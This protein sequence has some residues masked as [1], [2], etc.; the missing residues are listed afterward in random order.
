[1]A[2]LAVWQVS[3]ASRWKNIQELL[4]DRAV[5][6]E[7]QPP[8]ADQQSLESQEEHRDSVLPLLLTSLAFLGTYPAMNDYYRIRHGRHPGHIYLDYSAGYLLSGIVV[9]LTAD[10]LGRLILP[11]AALQHVAALQPIGLWAQLCQLD[12]LWPLALAAF[13]GG[14]MVTVGNNGLQRAMVLGLPMGVAMPIQSVSSILVSTLTNYALQPERNE[15]HLLAAAVLAFVAAIGCSTSLQL[16]SPHQP[17]SSGDE[18]RGGSGDGVSVSDSDDEEALTNSINQEGSANVLLLPI[19]A[20]SESEK[21]GLLAVDELTEPPNSGGAGI[22]AR[23][24]TA[25][26][27]PEMDAEVMDGGQVASQ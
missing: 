14:A 7:F 1:M 9:A 6:M 18:R 19:P 23:G 11:S 4:T 10:E 22:A 24:Q 15:P 8:D 17:G 12:D 5:I 26:T 2:D 16:R 13:L 3:R 20:T 21:A 25:P 27:G